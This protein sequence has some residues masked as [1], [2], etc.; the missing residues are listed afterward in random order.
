MTFARRRILHL[1]AGAA[2]AALAGGARAEDY[3]ARPVRIL[4]ATS[5]G[6]S[7]DLVARVIA[8]WLGTR[9]GQQFV[10]ENRPGGG[11]NI[12]TE[13][14]VRATPDGYTLFM[15]NSVNA[16]NTTYYDN[17]S[18]DFTTDMAPVANVLRSALLVDV[19]PSMPAQ[20]IPELIAY[21]KANAGKVNM[22]SGG[23]G[24]TGHV[25]GELFQMMAGVRMVHVPYRGESLALA[26]LIAGQVQVVFATTGSS[27]GFLKGGQLRALAVTSATPWAGL[28]S[29]PPLAQVLPG[30][31]ANSWSDLCAPKDTPASVVDVLNRAVN[32]GLAD[33]EVRARLAELGAPVD[34]DAN[35]PDDFGKTIRDDTKKWADV[36]RFSGAKAK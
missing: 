20:T 31:E 7:T 17:L 13:A 8:H 6:G 23:S 10:V 36:I 33:P 2:V 16:I 29:A 24:S 19:H 22:G 35:A 18:F 9:L 5:A 4:V 28:P 30:Y 27:I 12:G 34:P 1:A 21:A 26:D 15:A 3:P 25:A 14:A 32:A 11:N